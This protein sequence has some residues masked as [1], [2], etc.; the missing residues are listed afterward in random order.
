MVPKYTALIIFGV[1]YVLF[2][3]LPQRRVYVAAGASLLMIICG[4]ISTW[5][6]L[7]AINWNVIG[8]FVGNLIVADIL[9]ESRAPA[10]LA[11]LIAQRSRNTAWAVLLICVLT[12]FVSAF[13][14]N[15]ATVLLVAPVALSL[16][17][18]LNL[19]PK[20][21]LVG[22]A[23]SS[24]LQGA[25]TLIGDTPSMLLATTAGMDFMD[26]FFWHGR[27][28][29]F[30]AVQF[31]ALASFFVLY[32]VFRPL[33]AK[34]DLPITESVRSWFPAGLL[35]ALIVTLALVSLI[36]N[37][38]SYTAG[39][40]CM[41]AGGIAI[42]WE[43]LVNKGSIIEGL[44]SL[45]YETMFFLMGIFVLVGSVS[46]TGWI[47][48]F[49]HL[50]S[51]MVGMNV[52]AGYVLLISVAVLL[53]AVVDNIPFL[54]AM[55]PVVADMCSAMHINPTLYY[56]G[57]LIGASLGG[58]VTPIGASANIVVCGLLKK[59]GYPVR[60]GEFMA[61][62]VPFTLAATLAASLLVWWLWR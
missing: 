42:L 31:G 39:A 8:I 47:E 10:Y 21:M 41:L 9:V 53:S 43:K 38:P 56:F 4:V 11:E 23:V 13:V 50:L 14:D 55:L 36:P 28:G 17:R 49:A 33:T 24:N 5:H 62:G 7:A 19:N 29:I 1:A 51:D 18:K 22:I 25:A 54:A 44:R 26:F 15:V 40:I 45:D 12:G 16:A 61:I 60:F 3:A 48:Q 30:F 52:L 37:R 6:A 46:K 32:C 59:E 35:G 58:N 27:P 57:L 2:I 34:T 20:K